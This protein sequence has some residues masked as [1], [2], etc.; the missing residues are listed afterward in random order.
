MTDEKRTATS[1]MVEERGGF[2]W[3]L[4]NMVDFS[5][6]RL[7]AVPLAASTPDPCAREAASMCGSRA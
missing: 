2:V 6:L 7:Y 4:H 1:N 5:F 3:I